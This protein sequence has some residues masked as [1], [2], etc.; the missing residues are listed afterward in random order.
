MDKVR[1]GRVQPK[2]LAQREA[3]KV[4]DF[5]SHTFCRHY[6]KSSAVTK[7]CRNKSHFSFQL[8]CPKCRVGLCDESWN[9]TVLQRLPPVLCNISSTLEEL[10]WKLP[11]PHSN[12]WAKLCGDRVCSPQCQDKHDECLFSGKT[13]LVIYFKVLLSFD[14]R[15]NLLSL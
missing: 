12:T 3:G 1:E 4:A 2:K 6:E 14:E 8:P 11:L 5:F 13:H 7:E 10:N 15:N 9:T